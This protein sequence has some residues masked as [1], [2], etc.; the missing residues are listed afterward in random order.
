MLEGIVMCAPVTDAE[1]EADVVRFLE[2]ATLG[3]TE[4]LVQEV[5][6]KGIA[7]WLDEQIPMNVTRYT[8]YPFLDPP[9]DNT[10][11]MDDHTPP[12]TPEKYCGTLKQSATPVA[13]EFFRQSKTAPDQ[14][15]MRMAHVWHQIFV[16]RPTAAL[17][18][19][20]NAEFQQRLR[21]G[22][23][24][25]FESLLTKYALSPQLGNFQTWMKNVPEHDGI[26]PNEN[27]ARELMQ[28]FTIGVNSSTTTARQARRQRPAVPTYGQVGHRDARAHPDRLLVPDAAGRHGRLL[29]QPATI[30][31][32]T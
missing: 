10:L 27:F 23:F 32:A 2:Q 7:Q 24:G 11:C 1:R 4:A 21:D 9:I 22:A 13:W 14:V 20:A 6:A 12:V 29:G 3:P 30:T 17:Q 8:Q 31:S 15:R 16:T 18:T 28:L 5:K 25:T 19:Y 26:K